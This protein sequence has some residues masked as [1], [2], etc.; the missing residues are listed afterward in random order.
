MFVLMKNLFDFAHFFLG[1]AEIFSEAFD[2]AVAIAPTDIVPDDI[3]NEI[4]DHEGD[5]ERDE[6]K[7][8]E[9]Q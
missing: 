7:I 1:D 3:A 6:G 2:E 4:T 5:I 8:T 9:A